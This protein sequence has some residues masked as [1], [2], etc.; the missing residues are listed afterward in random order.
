MDDKKIKIFGFGQKDSGVTYHRIA[1]PLGFMD[2]VEGMVSNALMREQIGDSFDIFLYNRVNPYSNEIGLIRQGFGC[3]IVMDIDDDWNLPTNHINYWDYKN[4]AP[5]IEKNLYD[6][7]MVTVTHERLADKVRKFNNNVHIFPN[8]LP[9]GEDQF[10]VN[11]T[12]SD[13]VRFFWAGGCTHVEDLRILKNPVRRLKGHFYDVQMV[14]GGYDES[15]SISKHIW[16]TMTDFMTANRSLK[17]EI[18]RTLPVTEYL[19][20]Y[21]SADVMLIPLVANDWSAY[22]SNLKILEAASKK[23]PVICQGVPPYSD[24]ADAPVLWVKTQ[25]DWYRHMNFYIN[26]KNAILD[27]GEKLYE[28]AVK[29]YSLRKINKNRRQAFADLLKA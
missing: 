8:A 27:H 20:M 5:I 15:N 9:F 3:K 19:K 21:D 29:K 17:H 25:D 14:I 1:L 10:Q 26:N 13:R 28:W 4:H 11:K 16:D 6:A 2:N 12:E 23:V 24:D 22:K 18:L 7:D